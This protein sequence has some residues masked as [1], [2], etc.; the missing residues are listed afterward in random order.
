MII[1]IFPADWNA[2]HNLRRTLEFGRVFDDIDRKRIRRAY[3]NMRRQD[4]DAFTARQIIVELIKIGARTKV[5]QSS[6]NKVSQ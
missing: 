5:T 1:N 2:E 3:A 6:H 4:V